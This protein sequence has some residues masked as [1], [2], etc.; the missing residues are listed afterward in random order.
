MKI[1]NVYYFKT[2][3]YLHALVR[4]YDT[5][6]NGMMKKK[7]VEVKGFISI[8]QIRYIFVSFDVGITA[9][10]KAKKI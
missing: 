2:I 7:S 1:H 8:Y 6:T 9:S 3:L 4:K 10:S 5:I